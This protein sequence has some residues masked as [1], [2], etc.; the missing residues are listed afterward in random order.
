VGPSALDRRARR[1]MPRMSSA[2]ASAT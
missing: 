2:A 1:A